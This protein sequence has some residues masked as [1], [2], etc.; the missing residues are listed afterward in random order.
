MREETEKRKGGRRAG[1]M[2]G[3]EDTMGGREDKMGGSQD[4]MGGSERQ[5]K[6]PTPL[7]WACND[8]TLAHPHRER[9]RARERENC[10]KS[11]RS[12]RF[13]L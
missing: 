8:Q 7:P 1:K 12:F 4:K 2:G 13:A 6:F 9:A 5:R 10:L 11:L 3:R